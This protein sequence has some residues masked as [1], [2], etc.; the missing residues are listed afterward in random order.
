MT[1]PNAISAS[2]EKD[3]TVRPRSLVLFLRFMKTPSVIQNPEVVRTTT[4]KCR[5]IL[6]YPTGD[7]R[8]FCGKITDAKISAFG[9]IKVVKNMLPGVK[10]LTVVFISESH[11]LTAR[12]K[13]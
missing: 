11:I 8:T 1:I 7:D 2:V 10:M 9:F 13:R 5:K 3:L 12:K 4:V 6:A